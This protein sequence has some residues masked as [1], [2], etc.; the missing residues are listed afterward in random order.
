MSN[1][2]NEPSSANDADVFA[3]R[4]S[5]KTKDPEISVAIH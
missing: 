5:E 1:H 4:A 3:L 2:N